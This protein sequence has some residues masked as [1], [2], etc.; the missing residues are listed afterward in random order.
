MFEIKILYLIHKEIKC[1]IYDEN[2][3]VG[4]IFPGIL[5]I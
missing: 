3:A 4:Y 5:Q 2:V 1:G